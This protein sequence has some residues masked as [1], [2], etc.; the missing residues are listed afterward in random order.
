[1]LP[2]FASDPGCGNPETESCARA[3]GDEDAYQV[4]M[5][6]LRLAAVQPAGTGSGLSAAANPA[7]HNVIM[8]SA[9]EVW[10]DREDVAAK[11]APSL[12]PSLACTRCS[13]Q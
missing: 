5:Q 1:M 9:A 6:T 7:P 2:A 13:C 3:C 10:P 11:S 4:V 12:A 8:P